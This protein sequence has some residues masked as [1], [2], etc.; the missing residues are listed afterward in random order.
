M[1]GNY[2]FNHSVTCGVDHAQNEN[3]DDDLEESINDLT[4]AQVSKFNFCEHLAHYLDGS[5]ISNCNRKAVKLAILAEAGTYVRGLDPMK[6]AKQEDIFMRKYLHIVNN[7]EDELFKNKPVQDAMRSNCKG[8]K[9]KG[10]RFTS[11]NVYQKQKTEINNIRKFVA[12]FPGVGDMSILPSGL[13]QVRDMMKSYIIQL[14][15]LK[16]PVR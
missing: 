14:W 5:C 9:K 10:G 7:I 15:K 12:I 4:D 13:T 6:R 16:H 1:H 8:A 3:I 11:A 2:L